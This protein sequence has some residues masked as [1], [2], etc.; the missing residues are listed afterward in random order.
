M[1]IPVLESPQHRHEYLYSRTVFFEKSF[2]LQ[3]PCFVF[4]L[5]LNF[6]LTML[7]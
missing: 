6:E 4:P 3:S 7:Y 2:P 5:M 1:L